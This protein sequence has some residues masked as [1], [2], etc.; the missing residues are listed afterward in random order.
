R[1]KALILLIHAQLGATKCGFKQHSRDF[2]H[3]FHLIQISA[4]RHIY[5]AFSTT[6]HPT[7]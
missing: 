5:G 1:T 7:I 3:P 6:A 2:A 4:G